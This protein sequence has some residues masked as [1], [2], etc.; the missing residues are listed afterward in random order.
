MSEINN[1]YVENWASQQ[2]HTDD[3]SSSFKVF[4]EILPNVPNHIITLGPLDEVGNFCFNITG[5]IVNGTFTINK[6]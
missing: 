3:G 4:T 6:A 1:A 2:V 5:S